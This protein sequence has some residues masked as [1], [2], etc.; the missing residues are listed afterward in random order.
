M[1]RARC[2][3]VVERVV[4]ERFEIE[5]NDETPD[6]AAPEHRPK[7]RPAPPTLEAVVRHSRPDMKRARP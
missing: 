4:S 5:L 7:G 6:R 2:R 1:T 3:Y